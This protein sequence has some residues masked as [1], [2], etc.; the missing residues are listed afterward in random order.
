MYTLH[1]RPERHLTRLIGT[2]VQ[3]LL[4]KTFLLKFIAG[5]LS[6]VCNL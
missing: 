5:Q 6:K 1:A 3:S 2:D 4:G